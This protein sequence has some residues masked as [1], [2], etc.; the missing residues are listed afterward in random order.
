MSASPTIVWLR[1]DL[2]LVD[3]PALAAAAERGPVIPVF[4]WAP[5]EDAEWAPGGAQRWWLHESLQALAGALERLDSRLVVRRGPTR[6]ALDGLL[7]ETGANAVFFNRL[8]EPAARDRDRSVAEALRARDVEIGHSD[9]GL[10]WKPGTI[11]T[12]KG[13]PYKV[14]TPFWKACLKAAE[15]ARPVAAPDA[16][17]APEQ[18]PTGESIGDLE[19]L[20][21]IRWYEGMAEA[22]QPGEAGAHDRLDQFIDDA[23]A[24]YDSARDLPATDGVSRLS[25]HLHFG[26]ISPRSVWAE[27]AARRSDADKATGAESFLRELGWRE[28]A[29]HVLYHF[30]ATTSAPL[31]ER[32]SDFP[33]RSG[34]NRDLQ[35]WQKGRTGIPIVDAA[36]RQ[37]WQTGWMHNRARMI[38]ASLL[39]KNLRIHWHEGARWFW[40]TLV[41]ADLAN[42]TMGW[43]WS[44][45][46][47]ADAAPYFR[48]F[49][50]V[51]QGERFDP[52]GDYVRRF[53]PELAKLPDSCIHE[54]WKLPEKE[55]Q[56]LKFEP[57]ETY[58]EPIVD[59]KE[60]R[61][62]ALEAYE[63]V[64]SD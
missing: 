7:E 8:Y 14:F 9:A 51:R 11:C 45:G 15:P 1:R 58:P 62:A 4:I 16:L 64:K 38:V 42:N 33:W 40:D 32:F 24:D 56:R 31:N 29:H 49:N 27:I 57:G 54:P 61:K 25:P 50:P 21:K 20:P 60:S 18:W 53:V 5:E 46:C 43:Q 12:Q 39:V 48:I 36:M 23:L 30:P 10:L 34:E 59:L 47:G 19:L 44:A 3:N 55:R 26:E 35:A 28:F 2:R 63:R 17:E 6:D 22:W 41:D 52:D 37:L 13:D